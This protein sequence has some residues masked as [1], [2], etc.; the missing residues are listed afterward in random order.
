MAG[1]RVEMESSLGSHLK[2]VD[3]QEAHERQGRKKWITLPFI[4]GAYK[5]PPFL[6]LISL[7]DL[8]VVMKSYLMFSLSS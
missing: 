4:A 6:L 7:S 5:S 1:E 8:C 3:Q 2:T